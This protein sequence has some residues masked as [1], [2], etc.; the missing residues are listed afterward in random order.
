[1]KGKKRVLSAVLA[2]TMLVTSLSAGLSALAAETNENPYQTLAEALKNETVAETSRYSTSGYVTTVDDPT[3]EIEAAA[4]A[5]WAVATKEASDNGMIHMETDRWDDKGLLEYD[6]SAAGVAKLVKANLNAYLT[7]EEMAQYNVSAVIDK[8]VGGMTSNNRTSSKVDDEKGPGNRTYQL[9]LHRD[10]TSQLL[11]YDTVADL[12]DTLNGT[13]TYTWYHWQGADEYEETGSLWWKEQKGYWYN[14]LH[15]VGDESNSMKPVE[16]D[17]DSTAVDQLRAF[18]AYFTDDLLKTDLDAMEPEALA[19]LVE[20][21]QAAIDA[22]SLWGN[23]KVMTHFFNKDA[24]QDF[25]NNAK[26]KVDLAY[27]REYANEA[28]EL[29]ANDPANMEPQA[30]ID[31]DKQLDELC[32]KF[33]TVAEDARDQALTEVELTWDMVRAYISE[34]KVQVDVDKLEGYKAV[35]DEIVN[36]LPEDLTTIEDGTALQA[37]YAQLT[38]QMALVNDCRADAIALVFTEGTDYVT[39]AID[40][41]NIELQRRELL[42]D[43]LGFGAYFEP[44]MDDDLTAVATDELID[45]YR[46]PDLAEFAKV[47]KYEPEALDAVYGEGW[48]ASVEA[49]IASI[50]ATLTA[51]V[52]AQIDEAVNN[53]QEFGQITIRN[54]RTV[55]EA[56]G[57][58]EDRIIKLIGLSDEYQAKY[59]QFSAYSEE[60]KEFEESKGL[61]GWVKTDVEYPTRESM[62]GDIARGEDE[63]YEVTEDKVNQVISS[64]D[65]LMSNEDIIP[66]LES[67][68]VSGLVGETLKAAITNLI[69]GNLYT[70]KMV[71]TIMTTVYGK[72]VDIIN[73]L[74]LDDYQGL[75]DLLDSV[76]LGLF[77]LLDKIG[78]RLYPKNVADSLN[79]NYPA[80]I[81]A[82]KSAG[83]DWSKFNVN[84]DVSWGVHDRDSFVKAVSYSLC[85][86]QDVLRTVLTDK[87]LQKNPVLNAH[88]NI[89]AMDVYG[90]LIL[91]IFELLGVDGVTSSEDYNSKQWSH[92]LLPPILNPLLDLVEGLVDA[93]VSTLLELLPKLAY[94]MEFDQI[95]G[96]LQGISIS[97]RIYL[98]LGI[99]GESEL[100]NLGTILEDQLGSNNLYGILK[101]A[102]PAFDLTALGDINKLVPEILKL[103]GVDTNLVLPTIDQA[104]LASLGTLEKSDNGNILYTTDKPAV[105]VSVLRYVLNMVGDQDFMDS[106]F[107]L[108][109]KLTGAEIN[110]GDDVMNILKG[111]GDNPDG[112][113]CALTE[114]FVPY[115]NGYAATPYQ[116]EG[117]N[118]EALNPVTYSDDWTQD[119]AQ[120]L[121]DNFDEFVDDMMLILGGSGTPT[122]SEL[123]RSYIADQ[124]YTNETITSLVL[125]VKNLIDGIGIDVAPIL[126]LVGV[127]LDSWQDVTEGYDWGV[128]P[129]DTASFANGLKE[130]LEPFAPIAATLLSGEKD[131][132]ILGTVTLK[133]YPGYANGIIPLLENLGC[134][135]ADI[136]SAAEYQGLAANGNYD[137]MISA[138]INPILNLVDRVYENPIDTLMEILPNL[139][140]FI[141]NGG[142]QA[143][144]ENT[145]QSV[146]VL[147]D[148]V[149]PVYDLNFSLDLD[150]EQIL[151]DLVAGLEIDGQPLN[152]KIPFLSD[153][154]LL[155]TGTIEVYTSKSGA[156]SKRLV[157]ENEADFVTALLRNVVELLFYEDNLN[158]IGDLIANAT[159]LDA[160][161]KENLQKIINVFAKLYHQNNGVDKILHAAYVI[162]KGADQAA[163]GSIA[164]IKDFNERW[165][166]IFDQMYQSGGFLQDFAEWADEVLDFLSFGAINGDGVGTNGLVDFFDRLVAFFQGRVTD[167]SI[168]RTSADML[169]GGQTTLSLSFKPVTVKNKNVTWSSS[170]PSV[171]TVEN[172]VVTAVGVGDVEIKATTEDGG[173][174]VSCVVRVRAD[175]TELKAAIDRVESLG[176]TGDQA[177]YMNMYLTPAKEAF[178]AEYASQERVDLS[179]ESLLIALDSIDLGTK[180]DSVVITQN[181]S[182]VGETVYQK[183]KW[184]KKWNSTPVTL[185]IQINGG[186]LNQ[187]NVRSITWQYADWS[188]NKPE[189]DIEAAADGMSAL[190][191]AKNSVI[192]AHSCW[193]QVTVEDNYGNTVTSNPVKVR[194]YNY[195]WQ[196]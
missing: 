118:S 42:N 174:T 18:A 133:S 186:E 57:G 24:I 120:Y 182:P 45:N 173:F 38:T 142:L 63:Q 184:T 152:L 55:Q 90:N 89:A 129:G 43:A 178:E 34:V 97:G 140:Y 48:Y 176:L 183:V 126:S 169:V 121:A 11:Q 180:V 179:C 107:A 189:A 26:A 80:V 39:A 150:L 13:V 58:V 131:L 124:F 99:F 70:D 82:L 139:L 87:P 127:S 47:Q 79:G 56:I 195:D 147:L 88:V 109:G 143:C 9:V 14:Y 37:D 49:Y 15:W 105:L 163:G 92:E 83:E 111:L 66:L 5:F 159:G 73:G 27:A 193:I 125:T 22:C 132:S 35:I 69:D 137:Q 10:M 65:G 25:V 2:A 68:G 191:R 72:L 29:M 62:P 104:Y 167:V 33:D 154:S 108:I 187:D 44:K 157:V 146:F 119:Q 122:L 153:L 51:R 93:P 123:I 106:L 36:N 12:P 181:G 94:L 138:I 1:M 185:G 116:P 20:E 21:N 6:H 19:Q 84:G 81:E 155:A 32:A 103:A 31:L 192:G 148:T 149:R 128:T 74:P 59:D 160:T 190:I 171:A 3:G 177:Y 91:P 166:A 162:F 144:V 100:V 71:N 101:S 145:A 86:L 28:K 85:G 52:E 16:S 4:D 117:E 78:V 7:A 53:Y 151:V 130:A 112:V 64:L 164:A 41:L 135:D 98:D 115:E 136:M 113:I 50:D 67:F 17:A 54:Y 188:V 95:T 61:N 46:T 194:F 172:G 196:K 60:L 175:K 114:L 8:F 110:L 161:V 165:S 168:N 40:R 158:T 102:L 156:E 75:L 23:D 170:K 30:L 96:W 76:G 141:H 77:D 134:A